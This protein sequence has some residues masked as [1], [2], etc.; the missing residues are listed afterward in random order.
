MN[1]TDIT[2]AIG[3]DLKGYASL[4]FYILAIA[5]AFFNPWISYL[6]YAG[7]AAMWL[8]PDRRVEGIGREKAGG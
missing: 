5:V 7:V 8:I 3:S 2:R 4:F 1:P 6:I